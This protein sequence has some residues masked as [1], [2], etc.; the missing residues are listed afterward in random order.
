MSSIALYYPW[1]HFR[2]DNW[3]KLALLTWDSIAR[4]RPAGIEDRDSELVRHV[5]SESD[6]LAEFVPDSADLSL[7][8]QTFTEVIDAYRHELVE[9]YGSRGDDGWSQRLA[10]FGDRG[11]SNA[12]G[13]FDT[14]SA[15][16]YCGPRGAKMD[17][18]LRGMLIDNKLA[19]ADRIN[20]QWVLTSPKLGAVYSAALADAVAQHNR[21]V[22]VTDSPEMHHAVGALDHLTELLFDDEPIHRSALP[23]VECAYLRVALQAVIKPERLA[24]LSADQLV[25][26]RQRYAAEL[27]AFHTHMASLGPELQEIALITNV[28][29]AEAHLR[30]VY[31]RSTKP[32]LEEL[33]RALRSLGIESSAGTLTMKIDLNAA[34]GTVLGGVAAAAGQPAVAAA[35]IAITVVPYLAGRAKAIRQQRTTA[36]VSYLLAAEKK[37]AG[38]RW[39]P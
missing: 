29:A 33:R 39:S 17:A 26:F 5:R 20:P 8:S 18:S 14:R 38:R 3:L 13:Y 22:P 27:A 25:K 6:L 15:W 31:A 12:G 37:L 10:P 16:L 24:N 23:A 28:P 2:D 34:T 11:W 21:L 4:I 7:V 19:R 1:M 35:A 30:A 36:P 9:R 32:Q